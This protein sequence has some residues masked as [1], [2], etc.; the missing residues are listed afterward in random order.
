M[1]R[2]M[3]R[4]VLL[5]AFI[6]APMPGIVSQPIDSEMESFNSKDQNFQ[7]VSDEFEASA[8]EIESLCTEQAGLKIAVL[9]KSFFLLDVAQDSLAHRLLFRTG[10]SISFNKDHRHGRTFDPAG[11]TRSQLFSNFCNVGIQRFD[12]IRSNGK[13]MDLIIRAGPVETEPN[14]NSK[15]D[16]RAL[17]GPSENK[18]E[19][20]SAKLIVIRARIDRSLA[21]P[22][23]PI[24][25]QNERPFTNRQMRQFEKLR[26]KFPGNT[27]IPR[28]LSPEQKAERERQTQYIYEIQTKIVKKEATQQEI[29]EYYDYQIKGMTDRIELIDYVLKKPGAVLSPENREKLENVRAMNERTLKA[30]E[31]ARQRALKNAVD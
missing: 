13:A 10:D 23:N 20:G 25:P 1:H 30:Y 19:S 31:E 4:K 15:D 2:G 27:L 29:N 16:V 22:D 3:I 8:Q 24:N 11:P 5:L 28:K 7:F 17:L 26:Q 18:S 9:S 12:I 14:V 6:L 21:D